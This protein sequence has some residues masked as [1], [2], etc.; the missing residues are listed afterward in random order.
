MHNIIKHRENIY[1]IKFNN[2]QIE[3]FLKNLKL[4]QLSVLRI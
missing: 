1:K 4:N 3:F 2:I